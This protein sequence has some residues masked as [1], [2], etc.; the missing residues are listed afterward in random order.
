MFGDDK[1]R[2]RRGVLS[3]EDIIRHISVPLRVFLI[4][5]YQDKVKSTE[6]RARNPNIR[7]EAMFSIILHFG[8]CGS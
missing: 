4:K 6:K 7:R 3:M 2:F 1:T 8:V 5:Q